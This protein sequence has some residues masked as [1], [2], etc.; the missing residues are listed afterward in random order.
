MKQFKT[1][2]KIL[3]LRVSQRRP[4][5]PGLQ[6]QVPSWLVGWQKTVPLPQCPTLRNGNLSQ[7]GKQLSP[8]PEWQT[9][10]RK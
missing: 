5:Y 1:K 3:S 8:Q 2:L 6:K 9:H 4:S 10:F 7:L